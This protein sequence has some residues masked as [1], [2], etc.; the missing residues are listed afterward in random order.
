[1]ATPFQLEFMI[2]DPGCSIETTIVSRKKNFNQNPS[3]H[4]YTSI[5]S[6]PVLKSKKIN[7]KVKEKK[8]EVAKPIE[9]VKEKVGYKNFSLGTQLLEITGY[10]G[11]SSLIVR[12][13]CQG[14]DDGASKLIFSSVPAEPGDGDT[15]GWQFGYF[16]ETE[17]AGANKTVGYVE[18]VNSVNL[19]SLIDALAVGLLIS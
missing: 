17:I 10:S 12:F 19:S 4:S 13:Y 11:L 15:Y 3:V 7:A 2:L 1:M 5:I 6:A 9:A 18:I 16:F 14:P 8:A